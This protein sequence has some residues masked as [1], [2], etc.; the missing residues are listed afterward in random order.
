MTSVSF[1]RRAGSLVALAGLGVTL[2][3]AAASSASAVPTSAP[4]VTLEDGTNGCEGVVATPGSE[5]TS[6]TLVGGSMQPGETAVFD[7][8]YPVDPANVGQQFTI[9]DCVFIADKAFQKYSITFVPNNAAYTLTYAIEIP[10]GAAIGSE[11]CNYA[12]TTGGPS[13][14]QASNRKANPACFNVGGSLRVE[15][16]ADSAQGDLLPGATFS[17]LCTPTSQV[18]PIVVDG[19]DEAGVATTGVIGINGPEGTPCVVTELAPPDG[20]ALGSDSSRTLTIPRGSSATTEVFVNAAESDEC[21]DGTVRDDSGEC[22]EPSESPSASPSESPSA[23]PDETVE[24]DDPTPS[25]SPTVLGVKIVRKPAGLP[26]TGTPTGLL[27]AL[28]LALVVGGGALVLRADRYGRQ[29]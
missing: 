29:H 3:A 14:S 1:A 6:K 8:E 21:P 2:S 13:A 15:K 7:I 22:V 18:P 20:Y 11:Y 5:N 12:K 4:V 19:L 16:R 26:L 25:I 9:T 24:L 10:D 27:V 17:V 23:T 28:G